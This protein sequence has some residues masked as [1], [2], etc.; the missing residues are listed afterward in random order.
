[1]SKPRLSPRCWV[2]QQ[3]PDLDPL[4]LL[5]LRADPGES[6][7]IEEQRRAVWI[8]NQRPSET[9]VLLH[10]LILSI[11]ALAHVPLI[12]LGDI[13]LIVVCH[14]LY[15][16]LVTILAGRFVVQE[17]RYR[18]WRRDYLRSLARM[19]ERQASQPGA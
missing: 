10:L 3:F 12:I 1:M 14:S 16:V 13:N 18:R 2:F 4:S 17:A 7:S 15:L 5:K 19:V 9:R 11:G 8:W 6:I